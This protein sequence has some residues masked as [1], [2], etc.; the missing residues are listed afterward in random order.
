MREGDSFVAQQTSD[1]IVVGA[2]VIGSSIAYQLASAGADVLLA[3]PG[4]PRLPSASWASAGG[5]RTQNRDPREWALTIEASRRWPQL[6]QELGEDCQVREG[7][8]LYVVEDESALDRIHDRVVSQRAGGIA[9]EL[10]DARGARDVAPILAESV[11]G[12]IYTRGDGQANPR[13][14]TQAFQRAAVR[15]GASYREEAIAGFATDRGRVIGATFAGETVRAS[16]IVIAAGSWS[17]SLM[18]SLGVDLPVRPQAL[19]MLLTD[20]CEPVLLPTIGAEGRAISFKQLPTGA[21]FIGGGWPADVDEGSHSCATR[22]ECVEGSWNT[23]T[24]LVPAMRQRNLAQQWCGL[25]SESIDGVPFIGR[26]PQLDGLYV[27]I[28]FTGHGF[29]LSP[30]VGRAVADELL[31][32]EVPE[33]RGLDAARMT[34]FSQNTVARFKARDPM[35]TA[36]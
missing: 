18:T 17:S 14:T 6:E 11:V 26:V 36:G 30:A 4:A 16:V 28:G 10:L 2:G 1:F 13:L 19:Q 34:G 29:Q 7:G 9:V 21:F 8:H 5:L 24:E 33:L 3:D 27:A 23:A 15:H 31:G 22:H 12:A 20:P 25:E 35:W 32:H